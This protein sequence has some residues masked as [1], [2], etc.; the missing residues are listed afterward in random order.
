M[1][2]VD[3]SEVLALGAYEEIRARFRAR[4]I[5][6]KKTR[7]VLVGDHVSLVFENHDTVLYQVQEMLRTERISK[8]SGI[9]HEIETYNDL[10]PGPG[11]LSA[12]AML[13]YPEREQRDRML[14][15]LTGIEGRFYV[16]IDGAR[17]WS[18]SELR[19]V[20]EAKTT[21]VHYLKFD[22]GSALSKLGDGSAR[23]SV[24]VDHEAYRAAVELSEMT[25]ASLAS[26][27]ED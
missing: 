22:V 2:P 23:V 8:E 11:Q 14:G 21:A 5:E 17:F 4:I 13:E 20:D 3:R 25:R 1:K 16:E 26:D 10:V 9:Q 6:L 24:G 7:R 15:E 27:A 19:T 12:T 18:K